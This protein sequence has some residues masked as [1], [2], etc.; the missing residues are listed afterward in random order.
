MVKGA[1]NLLNL[2]LFKV[3]GTKKVREIQY[4]VKDLKNFKN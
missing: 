4:Q 3:L 1:K 2:T